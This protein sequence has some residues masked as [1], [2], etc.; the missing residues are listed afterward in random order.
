MRE[1]ASI[2]TEPLP[3]FQRPRVLGEVLV[4]WKKASESEELQDSQVHILSW[5]GDGVKNLGTI[6]KHTMDSKVIGSTRYSFRIESLSLAWSGL[7]NLIAVTVSVYEEWV[8]FILAF[9]RLH[10]LSHIVRPKLMD[11]YQISGQCL[12]CWAQSHDQ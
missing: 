12:N 3:F 1:M 10:T 5:E 4:N 9:G 8:L 11:I 7:T 6:T 2:I